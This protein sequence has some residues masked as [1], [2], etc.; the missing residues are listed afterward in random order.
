GPPPPPLYSYLLGGGG[1]SRGLGWS[2]TLVCWRGARG[3]QQQR[4]GWQVGLHEG[5]G[6]TMAWNGK[7]VVT[8]GRES[9]GHSADAEIPGNLATAQ[10]TWGGGHPPL[11]LS[12]DGREEG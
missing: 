11:A 4:Q 12:P 2:R 10:P 5:A 1:R 6:I 3:E 7:C 9:S 8:A